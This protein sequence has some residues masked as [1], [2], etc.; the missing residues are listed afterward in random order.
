MRLRTLLRK[1][2]PTSIKVDGAKVLKIEGDN[3]RRW[4][5]AEEN[6]SALRAKRIELLDDEG[7]ILHAMD[8]ELEAERNL[9]ATDD[10]EDQPL[11]VAIA[12]IARIINQA[13]DNGAL[14]HEK[15][16]ALAFNLLADLTRKSVDAAL[17]A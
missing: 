10:D 7:G 12:Q 9:A 6:V 8:L 13:H 2:S 14:R 1:F 5:R 11:G 17:N 4:A 15:A 16:Y 3:P